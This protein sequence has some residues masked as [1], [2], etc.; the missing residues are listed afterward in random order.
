MRWWGAG[1]GGSGR[2]DEKSLFA[3]SSKK[4]FFQKEKRRHLIFGFK[5]YVSQIKLDH[6]FTYFQKSRDIVCVFFSSWNKFVV[7]WFLLFEEVV[8]IKVEWFLKFFFEFG[9]CRFSAHR[10]RTEI[11]IFH[12]KSFVPRFHSPKIQSS[13][14]GPKITKFEVRNAVMYHQVLTSPNYNLWSFP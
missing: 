8:K 4:V 14:F 2:D 12:A 6:I 13:Y 10:S 9:R 1:E 3:K 7:R 11:V 5:F